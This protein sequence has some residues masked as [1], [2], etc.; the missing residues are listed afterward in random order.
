MLY[1]CWK[2]ICFTESYSG[3]PFS[4]TVRPKATSLCFHLLY[5]ATMIHVCC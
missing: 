3:A 4:L 5:I 1:T 2:D